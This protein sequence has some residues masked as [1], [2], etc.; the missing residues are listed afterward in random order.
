M[1]TTSNWFAYM[2]FYK[3]RCFKLDTGIIKENEN[4]AIIKEQHDIEMPI[5]FIF[6]VL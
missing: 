6:Q 2:Q 1:P 5:K 4:T 3:D